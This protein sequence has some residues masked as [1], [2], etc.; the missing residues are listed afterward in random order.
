MKKLLEY[1]NMEDKKIVQNMSLATS[2]TFIGFATESR[3]RYYNFNDCN[4]IVFIGR[5]SQRTDIHPINNMLRISQVQGYTNPDDQSRW[6]IV[7]TYLLC[8]CKG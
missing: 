7:L 5:T 6:S 3:E 4:H 8:S 1:E 2:K